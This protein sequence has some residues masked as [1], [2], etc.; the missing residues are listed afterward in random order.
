MA[1]ASMIGDIKSGG[2]ARITWNAKGG[3]LEVWETEGHGRR[4]VQL[5][6]EIPMRLWMRFTAKV[7]L[8]VASMA[9]DERWLDTEHGHALRTF[10]KDDVFPGSIWPD[11]VPLPVAV[12]QEDPVAR[13]LRRNQ[14]LLAVVSVEGEAVVALM[15][16]GSF[17]STVGLG[18]NLERG[19]DIGWLL[20]PDSPA[21][22][23]RPYVSLMQELGAL[24][25]D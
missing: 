20:D 22:E 11:G 16:F 4:V 10:V 6:T 14:H 2:R 19:G 8:A 18:V 23:A 21:P 3:D 12:G 5:G 13:R 1:Q 25:A 7:A 24:L 17:A 9:V 15:L